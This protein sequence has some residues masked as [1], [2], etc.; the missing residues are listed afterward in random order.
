MKSG[1]S[2]AR[3]RGS[4]APA[5]LRG[6][7]KPSMSPPPDYPAVNA[8][9]RAWSAAELLESEIR[10]TSPRFRYLRANYRSGPK[11]GSACACPSP[12]RAQRSRSSS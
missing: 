10:V 4:G 5:A 2:E 1:R 9:A 3:R 11:S 12:P 8:I 7:P 6:Q